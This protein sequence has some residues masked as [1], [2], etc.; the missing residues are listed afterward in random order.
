LCCFNWC[1]TLMFN[2]NVFKYELNIIWHL[3]FVQ[4]FL[5]CNCQHVR[6]VGWFMVSSHHYQQYFSYMWWSAGENQLYL[7]YLWIILNPSEHVRGCR[8]RDHMVVGFTISCAIKCLSPL[9]LWVGISFMV[10][11]TRCKIMW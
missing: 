3:I 4:T 9:A 2:N 1:C 7:V 11:C 10:R 6:L 8:N 5:W